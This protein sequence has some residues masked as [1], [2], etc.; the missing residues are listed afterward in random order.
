MAKGRWNRSYR[1]REKAWIRRALIRRDGCVCSLCE[2]PI[3]TMKDV[4][5]DH[6]VPRSRGGSDTIENLQ[7]AHER[8]NQ[9]KDSMTPEQWAQFQRM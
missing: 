2:E 8:C 1:G 7:L 5:L 6:I 9:A 3:A 4:T